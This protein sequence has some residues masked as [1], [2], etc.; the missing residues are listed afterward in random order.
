MTRTAN[1]LS[2]TARTTG[3]LIVAVSIG[4]LVMGGLSYSQL[5]TVTDTNAT[6]RIDSASRTAATIA[7]IRLEGRFTV[8]QDREGRLKALQISHPNGIGI[9]QASEQFDMALAEMAN[10]NQGTASLFRF[11]PQTRTFDRFATT[12]HGPRREALAQAKFGPEHPAFTAV[13][14]GDVHAGQVP[15]AERLRLA[16]LTPVLDAAGAVVGAFYTDIGWVDD[17]LRARNKL[18][19]N[20]LLWLVIN[21]ACVA[22]FG[23]M[24]LYSEMRPLRVIASFAHDLAAGKNG[25]EVPGMGRQDEV[26][27]LAEGLSRVVE[28]QDNLEMLAFGDPLTGLGNRAGYFS[29]LE[30]VVQSANAGEASYGLL[31]LDLDRF[32]DT[33]D[34]FGHAAGDELLL[35]ARDIILSTLNEQDAAARL[36]G[37]DFVI[38]TTQASTVETATRFCDN[39]IA[40]LS[41]PIKI[42]QGEVHSSCSIGVAF[43]PQHGKTGDEAH[44]NADLALRQAKFEG[45]GRVAFYNPVMSE[46]SQT[47]MTLA[48]LLRQAL[49]VS[50]LTVHVQPQVRLADGKLHGFE[51]LARWSHPERGMIPPSEF[52]PVAE[53]SGLI[54]QLGQRILDEACRIARSWRDVNF[55]FGHISVN[56]SPIQL[57]QPNFVSIVAES[58]SRHGLRGA[59]ICLEVTESVFIDHDQSHVMEVFS[60]LRALGVSISLDDFG[61]GYSSLGY[62]NSLPLD[63]LKIDRAFITGADKDVRKR[64]LLQGI[65][66]L[67]KGLQLD[68]VAEG[69]ETPEEIEV[70]K[71]VGC[72]IVQGY[73]FGRPVPA[74]KAQIEADRIHREHAPRRSVLGNAASQTTSATGSAISRISAA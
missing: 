42:A 63:Q 10:I 4:I 45:R 16:Y 34:A 11:N 68:V 41:E 22:T 44:R 8:R 49:E 6:Q 40:R 17:L 62:L 12:Y 54:P 24:I 36:A 3:L 39:L 58:L 61:A 33:N 14:K 73:H 15:A 38:L 5:N 74:V 9:L 43:L 59:D 66:A 19:E 18:R 35:R 7:S 23:A 29:L 30:H 72:S 48:R 2:L 37:D 64:S 56:V 70:L 21:L 26:G 65:V 20:M 50:E 46:K 13:F 71:E 53:S 25:A 55:E 1:H 67:G 31:M 60:D 47:T 28:L 69:A 27:Y 51:A 52:I 32:K 57:W